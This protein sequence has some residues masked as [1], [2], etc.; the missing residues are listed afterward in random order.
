MDY[1][2]IHAHLNF[3]EYDAD[4]AEMID[5]MRA[6][7]VG[8]INIGIDQKTSE[9]VVTLAMENETMWA[10]IGAHPH[11]ADQNFDYEFY[12]RLSLNSKV[13]AIGECGLDYFRVFDQ[14]TKERQEKLFRQHIKLAKE[15]DKPLMLHIRE[16]YDD[17]LMI[18]NDERAGRTHAHFF[19]GDWTIAKKFLDRGDTISFTG[20]I[21]FTNAYDEI[22]KWVPLDRLLAETDAPYV[23]PV[24][25]RWRRNEPAYVVEIYKRIAT[26][27][28]LPLKTVQM[29]LLTNAKRVF[30]LP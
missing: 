6:A 4:W 27:K 14:T 18:L 19:A 23:A 1:I 10:A 25:Y 16:A 13:V 29:A 21:T 28:N 17:A 7:A 15:V 20:V 5:R 8:V 24:P 26:I 3:P 9:E 22:I 11:Q 12:R 2:D 30:D